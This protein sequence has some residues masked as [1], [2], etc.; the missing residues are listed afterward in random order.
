[1]SHCTHFLSL[2]HLVC[3][4]KALLVVLLVVFQGSFHVEIKVEILAAGLL[5]PCPHVL[6][7]VSAL[8][9]V[10]LRLVRVGGADGH[11]HSESVLVNS[12][13]DCRDAVSSLRKQDNRRPSSQQSSIE[14][15]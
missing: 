6:V 15:I 7:D 1:M 5:P 13:D 4:L 10:V 8:H 2:A 12:R 9:P 11:L 14:I 3:C